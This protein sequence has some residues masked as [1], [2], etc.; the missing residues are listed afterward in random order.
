MLGYNTGDARRL[1]ARDQRFCFDKKDRFS[2]ER[3]LECELKANADS[4]D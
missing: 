2:Y 1:V 4:L 3:T